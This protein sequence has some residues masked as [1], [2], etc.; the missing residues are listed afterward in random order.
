MYQRTLEQRIEQYL[1]RGRVVTLLGARRTGKTTLVKVLLDKYT[2]K[3]TRYLNCDLQS[4]QFALEIQEAEPL[5]AFIGDQDLVVLD[6]AQNIKEIG[7]VLKILVDT[8]PEMQIIATGSSSFDLVNKTGEPLTGRVFAFKLYPL[9]LQEIAGSNGYSVIEPQLEHFLRFG[10]YPAIVPLSNDDAAMQLD[11]LAANYL[12]KDIL[13]FAG[14]KRA[15]IIT[16]LV[17]LLALQVGNEVSYNELA[18]NLG[19]DRKTVASY[20]DLLEQC[21]V[22][23]RLGA[24][25]RN[26]RK[27]VAKSQKVYFY[28]LGVRNALL[29][30]FAPV[31][32]RT[33]VGALWE[34][35]CIVER[36]KYAD[37]NGIRANRYFWRTYD[38]KE[39]DYIE[40]RDGKLTGFECKWNP[41]RRMRSPKDF[42]DTYPGSTINQIDRTNYWRYLIPPVDAPRR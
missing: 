20:L 16:D 35:F 12:Y 28:D 41:T 10:L 17:R 15:R 27:E 19:V 29:Q 3:R 37:N 36:L 34:N 18:V 32:L 8:Y 39:I 38:Q 42:L 9:S 21:F 5:K 14:V 24:F 30:A 31:S 40:E 23:F 33:D 11:E 22:V 25:S 13:A 6:E 1:F 26:L 2:D 4:V 7:K